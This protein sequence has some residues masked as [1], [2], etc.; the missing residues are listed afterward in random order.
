MNLLRDKRLFLFD[1]DGTLAVGDT[2]LEGSADLLAHIDRIGGRSLFITNNSTKSGRDYV[3]RFRKVFGLTTTEDQFITSGYLTLCFLK[4][5]YADK[6]VFVLG[7]QSFVR[8]LRS[9]GLNITEAADSD[10][11]CIVA[12]YDSELTYEKLV[13]ASRLLLTTDVPLSLI[14]I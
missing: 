13:H 3:E 10:V 7:T 11:A 6:K 12:A 8:E 5:H 9:N 2:L 14:H 4:E 1:I